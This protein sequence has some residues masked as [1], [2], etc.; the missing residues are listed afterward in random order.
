[1]LS[2]LRLS[3][4]T[5]FFISRAV[6]FLP[7]FWSACGA[8][9]EGPGLR[10]GAP[11]GSVAVAG[12]AAGGHGSEGPCSPWPGS[13]YS[14]RPWRTGPS[15]SSSRPRLS[16]WHPPPPS[17]LSLPVETPS[18]R[19]SVLGRGSPHPPGRLPGPTLGLALSA[20]FAGHGELSQGL[21][22]LTGVRGMLRRRT[23]NLLWSLAWG[24]GWERGHGPHRQSVLALLLLLG[25]DSLLLSSLRTALL[26][27]PEEQLSPALPT[28]AP[29]HQSAWHLHPHPQLPQLTILSLRATS[30]SSSFFRASKWLSMSAWSSMRSLF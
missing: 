27:R 4:S 5:F 21:R 12:G 14:W 24:P 11:H 28:P 3:A 8:Q 1:M 18:P 16:S 9:A 30:S 26:L 7:L 15:S 19:P 29:P 10:R 23:G 13:C 22:S 6:C 17:G 2:G 25:A 20:G